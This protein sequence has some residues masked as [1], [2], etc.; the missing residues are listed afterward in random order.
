MM[1][2][3]TKT[4]EPLPYAYNALE[5]YIDEQTMRI[6]HDKHQQTYFDKFNAAIMEFPEL[7]Q[8]AVPEILKNLHHVPEKI[9]SAVRNHGGGYYHHS[10]FWTV[11]K[12]EVPFSGNI[13]KAIEKKWGSLDKFKEEFTQKA[14][15]LFGSGWTWLVLHKDELEIMNLPNQDSPLSEGKTPLLVLDLWEHAYYL[16]YQNKRAEYAE[17]FWKIINWKQ[18]DEYYKKSDISLK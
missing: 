6:H 14:L 1:T 12:K 10:F 18:V 11:L 7:Q 15:S 5:P 17:N 8:K 13:A 2:Q 3:N 16:K 9:Q 4:L